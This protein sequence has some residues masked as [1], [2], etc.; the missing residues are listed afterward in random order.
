MRKKFFLMVCYLLISVLAGITVTLVMDNFENVAVEKRIRTELKEGI[1]SAAAAFKKSASKPSAEQVLSFVKS[2]TASVLNGKV[3]II[4]PAP[5]G[6]NNGAEHSYLFTYQEGGEKVDFYIVSSFLQDELAILNLPELIFGLFTTIAIFSGIIFYT[7]KKKQVHALRQN[8][9]VR[10]TEIKKVLEEHEALAL[11][12]RM[13]ATLA[14]ELKTPIAT[15]SNL[16]QVLPA[17]I[18]DQHF[19]SRFVALTQAE[20]QRTEQLISNLLVFGKDFEVITGEWILLD[21]FLARAAA[22]NVLNVECPPSLELNGDRFY[23]GLLFENLLRNSASAGAHRVHI[24]AQASKAGESDT[25]DIVLVDDGGGFPTDVELGTLLSPFVTSRSSG[26]GLGLYLAGKILR[27]HGGGIA[28]YR[29]DCGAGVRLTF[30]KKWVKW[31]E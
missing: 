15:I 25:V 30:P 7:E 1:R 13:T 6:K 5:A 9:E 21:P 2:Y 26:T 8:F 16:V 24:A 29:P 27:A 19:T 18:A 10:H 11:L 23:L 28:L 12:G 4:D 17:R 22:M 14:H 31:H 3:S 20:L